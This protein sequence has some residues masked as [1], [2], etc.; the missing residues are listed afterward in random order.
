[1][2]FL[3]HSN[4]LDHPD[5]HDSMGMQEGH[6]WKKLPEHSANAEEH[7][8]QGD[9]PK[10]RGI[11]IMLIA[12]QLHACIN[13]DACATNSLIQPSGK[14]QQKPNS[15]NHRLS[16]ANNPDLPAFAIRS[17]ISVCAVIL[18]G[19]TGGTTRSGLAISIPLRPAIPIIQPTT[20]S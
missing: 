11:S 4:R 15:E 20:S 7:Q 13:I 8:A 12:A 17:S 19:S 16:F 18:S 14:K 1:M 9:K 10:Y 3:A 6:S 2:G 5:W